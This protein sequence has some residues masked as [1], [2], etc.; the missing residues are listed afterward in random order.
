MQNNSQKYSHFKNKLEYLIF[1]LYF[2]E[3][4]WDFNVMKQVNKRMDKY[5][6]HEMKSRGFFF[7][8]LSNLI[9][10]RNLK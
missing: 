7:Y 2:L 5:Q 3:N 10:S 9:G 4:S 1:T 8:K 6:K